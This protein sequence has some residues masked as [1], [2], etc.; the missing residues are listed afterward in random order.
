MNKSIHFLVKVLI[1]STVLSFRAFASTCPTISEVM[2][3]SEAGQLDSD[4]AA[5]RTAYIRINTLSL[6]P[7]IFKFESSGCVEDGKVT[8]FHSSNDVLKVIFSGSIGD[9]SWTTEY[10]FNSGK[11]IFCYDK[12]IGGPAEGKVTTTEYRLYVKAD[13]PIKCLKNKRTIQPD[14]KAT[15]TV[16]TAYKLLKAHKTKDFAAALCD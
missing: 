1:M 3:R 6:K 10:Y 5:I 13:R 15:E 4:I 14:G 9:G 2:V 12:L 8:Y 7:E 16:K 11:L